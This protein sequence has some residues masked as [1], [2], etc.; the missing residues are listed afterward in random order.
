MN[1]DGHDTGARKDAQTDGQEEAISL[2]W[3]FLA[4]MALSLGLPFVGKG[5]S[6]FLGHP[7]DQILFLVPII[8]TVILISPTA[9]QSL[10]QLIPLCTAR[11]WG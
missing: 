1:A 3:Q 10:R 5:L 4:M 9:P 11:P 6:Q 7:E 8:L 2:G